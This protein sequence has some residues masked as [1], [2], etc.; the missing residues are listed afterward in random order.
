VGLPVEDFLD[1]RYSDATGKLD[2]LS[3]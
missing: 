1:N 3:L 2:I